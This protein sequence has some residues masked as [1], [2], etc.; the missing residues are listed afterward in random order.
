MTVFSSCNDT[1]K[2][3]EINKKTSVS[4]TKADTS[5][6]SSYVYKNEEEYLKRKM[7][8]CNRLALYD[9]EKGTNDF[10]LRIWF[11]PSMWDPSTLYILK[12]NDTTWT[13][14]HYQIYMHRAT[15]EDHHY[16]DPVV[17]YYNNPIV[18]SVVMESVI[19]QKTN[20]RTYINNL[21][22]DSL[23]SLQTESSI[24]GKTFAMLDGHRYL[25]EISN[26]RKYKYLFYTNPEYFQ[27]KDINHKRFIDFKKRLIEPIIYNGMRNP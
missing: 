9:I 26:E 17:E 22:L 11:I 5:I 19:P 15:S 27:D 7:I 16:D 24:K 25:L 1:S 2:Q 4:I 13:L 21:Q 12:A 23:W 10:E 20:W 14:F 18:D 8:L 6:T 3:T